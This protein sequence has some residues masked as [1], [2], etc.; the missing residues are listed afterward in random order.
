M[1]K[2]IYNRDGW[3]LCTCNVCGTLNYVEPHGT[4]E[5]C[6]N[7]GTRTEHSNI[8][9]EYRDVSGCYL[10]RKPQRS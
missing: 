6:S 1:R 8:S 4:T 9:Y 7:C 10:I 5:H 3:V 2:S